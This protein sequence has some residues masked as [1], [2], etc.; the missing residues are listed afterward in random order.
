M[1][2]FLEESRRYTISSSKKGGSHHFLFFNVSSCNRNI[3]LSVVA[4]TGRIHGHVVASWLSGPA[5][6]AWSFLRGTEGKGAKE[7]LPT[8]L[9]TVHEPFCPAL[10][11]RWRAWP[12]E[13]PAFSKRAGGFQ[14]TPAVCAS[15]S[16][17][18]SSC[19]QTWPKPRSVPGFAVRCQ[20]TTPQQSWIY[21]DLQQSKLS[22][23]VIPSL[24]SRLL[25]I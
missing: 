16:R 3:Q 18:C 4:F 22:L 13:C 20:Q 23:Q 24:A 7:L 14:V 25:Q 11:S 21:E 17:G 19:K 2:V 8:D 15:G 9:N 10:P 12:N 5:A 1:E 6:E